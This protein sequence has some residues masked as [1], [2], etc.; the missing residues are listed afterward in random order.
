MMY[1][2]LLSFLMYAFMGED[3][4][5]LLGWSVLLPVISMAMVWE[6][7]YFQLLEVTDIWM[8]LVP[9][10]CSWAVLSKS[11][12]VTHKSSRLYLRRF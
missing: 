6:I 5:D 4:G 2:S 8:M 9:C 3:D 7:L 10:M 11:V 12:V 1:P